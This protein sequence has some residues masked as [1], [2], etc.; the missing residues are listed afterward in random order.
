LYE[1][2]SSYPYGK[3]LHVGGDE[4]GNLGMSEQAKKSGLNAMQLQMQWLQKVCAF[5]RAQS[6]SIFWDDMVFKLSGLY[7][8]TW[9]PTVPVADVSRIWKDSIQID[10]I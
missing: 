2:A 9:D 10:E 5:A 7:Q 1:D 3:Y 4:V 8:T 6:Y